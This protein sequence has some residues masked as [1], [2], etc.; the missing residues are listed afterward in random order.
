MIST[1]PFFSTLK[2]NKIST[3]SLINDYGIS[4]GVL[5]RL[6]QNRNVTLHT[7]DQLCS[8]LHCKVSDI[9]EF[10]PDSQITKNNSQ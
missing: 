8:I 10:I 7:I 3:Y 6:H 4:K 9:I 5:D 2:R 1:K